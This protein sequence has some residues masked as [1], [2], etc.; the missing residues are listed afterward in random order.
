[1]V[2]AFQKK[3]E[4][5]KPYSVVTVL[6]ANWGVAQGDMRGNKPVSLHLGNLTAGGRSLGGFLKKGNMKA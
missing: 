2:V 1:M 4:L 6:S 5:R 3:L